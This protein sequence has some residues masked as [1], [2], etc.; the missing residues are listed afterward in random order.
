[1]KTDPW[2]LGE[3]WERLLELRPAEFRWKD[4]R[5]GSDMHLG[6]IVQEVEPWFPELVHEEGRDHL[7]S[8][9]YTGLIPPLIEATKHLTSREDELFK[10][11][12]DLARALSELK[13]DNERLV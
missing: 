3:R 6:L 8:I 2:N 4:E 7:L 10:Q 9:E 11:A 12:A 13:T 1:M 5:M